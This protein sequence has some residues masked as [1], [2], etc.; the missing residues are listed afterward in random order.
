MYLRQSSTQSK[1]DKKE[2]AQFN[3]EPS[4]LGKSEVKRS[5]QSGAQECLI[6]RKSVRYMKDHLRRVH[7]LGEK[8]RFF[9]LNFFYKA[10]QLAR[11][12]R[13]V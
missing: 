6:C 7:M 9:Y 12:D 13:W 5:K 8:V 4:V 2:V 11:L 3:K 10:P 1:Q